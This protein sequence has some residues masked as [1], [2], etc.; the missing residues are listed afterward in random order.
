MT[1][2]LLETQIKD[3]WNRQPCNIKHGQSEVGTPAFFHEVSE[4][5]YRVEPHIPAFAEFDAWRGQRVL[6]IGCGIATDGEEFAR[7]GA[8]YVG[9]DYSDQS[10]ELARR[11]RSEEHTSEL[12]SH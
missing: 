5:R 12:Q 3:Y 11:R 1:T 2:T 6:E 8:D 10:V 4:R 9:I 7:F